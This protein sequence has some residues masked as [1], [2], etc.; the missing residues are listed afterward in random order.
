MT[1]PLIL[2]LVLFTVVGCDAPAKTPD[3]VPPTAMK[4]ACSH[5]NADET[6]EVFLARGPDGKPLRLIVTPTRKL[7]DAGN[8]IF[9]MAGKFL[10]SETSR[11]FPRDDKALYE[12]EK[13]RV[14]GLM[15]GAVTANEPAAAA[16]KDHR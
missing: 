15:G 7:P 9:D 13:Q 11:E 16:C 10:G 3:G 5:D 12:Q 8:L 14:A 1:K 6:S 4:S 2:A